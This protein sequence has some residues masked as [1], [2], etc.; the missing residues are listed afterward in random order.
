MAIAADLSGETRVFVK[1]LWMRDHLNNMPN[2]YMKRYQSDSSVE[3][4]AS[5]P[6]GKPAVFLGLHGWCC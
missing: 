3:S 2:N 1:P 5:A 6:S 4:Q